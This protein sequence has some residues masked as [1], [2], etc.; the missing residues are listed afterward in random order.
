MWRYKWALCCFVA[1]TYLFAA[2]GYIHVK[3]VLAQYLIEDAWNQSLASGQPVSPWAWA[4]TY[5]VAKLTLAQEDFYVLSGASGRVLAF[6]PGHMSSTSMPGE[7]GNAVISGH[8]DT[9]FAILQ[10]LQVGDVITTETAKHKS[11][12]EVADIRIAHQSQVELT[13]STGDNVLT[14]ITCYPFAGI[15]PNPELRYVVRA[16]LL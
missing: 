4:D 10:K 12:Y 9:H 11:R 14:L 2:S 1:S 5:P 6:G 3:A 8:R 13:E 16:V 7:Q 15:E